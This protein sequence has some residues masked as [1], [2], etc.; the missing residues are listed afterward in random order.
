MQEIEVKK[1][2]RL[3]NPSKDK[4]TI[5]DGQAHSIISDAHNT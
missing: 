3:S 1:G 2:G 5:L 4:L